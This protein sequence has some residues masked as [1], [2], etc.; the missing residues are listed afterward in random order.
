MTVLEDRLAEYLHVRRQLGFKL[1]LD[2][3]LL[4]DF[5]AFL[6]TAGAERITNDLSVTWARRPGAS[7]RYHMERLSMVR[8]FAR[9]LA[10]IDPAHEIPPVDLLHARE[11]RNAAY[12]YSEREIGELIAAAAALTPAQRGAT[13]RTVIGVMAASGLRIG[14]T[15]ALDRGDVDLEQGVLHIRDGKGRRHRDVPVHHTTTQVL[16]GYAR[17]RDRS[18]RRSPAPAPWRPLEEHLQV[19]RRR[20]PRVHRPAR[21]DELQIGIQ[22][23]MPERDRPKLRPLHRPDQTRHE[24]HR[25]APSTRGRSA[26]MDPHPDGAHAVGAPLPPPS[27][28]PPL[29]AHRVVGTRRANS[30]STRS[31]GSS[32]TLT[33]HP[34]I[35]HEQESTTRG[36]LHGDL[37]L[38][39]RAIDRTAPP[40]TQPG[41]YRATDSLLAFLNKL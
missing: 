7:A 3:Y 20:Q 38:K 18:C 6:E 32:A 23:G 30:R 35:Q 11:T 19:I 37:R 12:L 26:T 17:L 10:T 40:H 4:A 8:G 22:P 9:Y 34:H 16:R 31:T 25:T 33:Y 29:R 28:R 21:G 41:R 14:E 1:Q 39:Q 5:V 2:G 13:Y 36:Y 24:R 15:L 27:G